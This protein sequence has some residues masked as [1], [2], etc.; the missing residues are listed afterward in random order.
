[1][2]GGLSAIDL[3]AIGAVFMLVLCV[4]AIGG[5]LWLQSKSRR[6]EMVRQR[7][8]MKTTTGGEEE[9]GRV[10]RLF[11]DGHEFE[12]V[13]P[14]MGKRAA[15]P[16][17]VV[18]AKCKAAGITTPV[19]TLLMIAAAGAV[20]M[21][22]AVW[23]FT[24]H[25]PGAL[26]AGGAVV[27]LM[28]TGVK[29]KANKQEARF[30]DQFVEALDLCARS[31]RAGHTVIAGLTLAAEE[32]K[33]PVKS[34]LSDIVQQQEMGVSLEQ[35]L[36]NVAEKHTSQDLKLFAASVAVQIKAGGN[37]SETTNRLSA[38]IR[39]RLRLGRRVRVLIAQTQMSKQMLLGLPV[40]VFVLL[41]VINPG[42]MKPMYD[43]E[44]GQTLLAIC[45]GS[46]FIGSWAMSKMA[47]IK[48]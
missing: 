12:A 19:P 25:T 47:V 20:G 7:V 3:L 13:L 43:T 24:Q 9:G 31:L 17:A 42:Y 39:D 23:V 48:Y 10:V 11:H 21:F 16:L 1:M 41:N 36:R 46:M 34:V 27:Y 14:G 32:S 15:S 26:L 38:V 4:T 2:I 40:V 45:V 28:W 33:D 44:M 35:A 5:L 18:K 8:G 29:M 37:L 6:S 30:D 22:V